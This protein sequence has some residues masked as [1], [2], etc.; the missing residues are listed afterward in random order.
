MKLSAHPM[1]TQP[2]SGLAPDGLLRRL[3]LFRRARAWKDHVERSLLELTEQSTRLANALADIDNK[4]TKLSREQDR[5]DDPCDG[6][7]TGDRICAGAARSHRL[8]FSAP[9][10]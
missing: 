6:S 2:L 3:N 5:L 7:T 9:I 10:F 1:R 8:P 4:L